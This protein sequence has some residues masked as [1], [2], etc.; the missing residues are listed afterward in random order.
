MDKTSKYRRQPPE[1][2]F[3]HDQAENMRGVEFVIHEEMTGVMSI[4]PS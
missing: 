3:P 2:L 4:N 1:E